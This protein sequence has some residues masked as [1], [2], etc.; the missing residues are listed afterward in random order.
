MNRVVNI[1]KQWGFQEGVN[2]HYY[3]F[4]TPD[5]RVSFDITEEYV[6]IAF[7]V[8]AGGGGNKRERLEGRT[9][10]SRDGIDVISTILALEGILKDAITRLIIDVHNQYLFNE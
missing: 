1:I 6:I 9:E 7:R 3:K 10:L 4:I 8:I 5:S 2:G